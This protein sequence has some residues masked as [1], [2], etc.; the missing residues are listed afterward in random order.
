MCEQTLDTF[1]CVHTSDMNDLFEIA[2][3]S[4]ALNFKPRGKLTLVSNDV[5]AL[6]EFI[7]RVDVDVPAILSRDDDWLTKQELTL[8]GWYRQQIIKLRSYLFCETDNF[9]SLGADTI[10]LQPIDAN[11]LLQDGG[12]IL[13]YT[14]RTPFNRHYRYERR[15]VN[16]VARLLGVEPTVSRR[17]V[18]FINDLFCFNRGKLI[19][20]NRYLESL[21][22][23]NY[24]YTMLQTLN[25]K[26]NRFGEWTLYNVYLLDCLRDQGAI[27]N[28]AEGFLH[29]V[30]SPLGLRWHQ[31]DSKTVHLVHKRVNIDYVK[32]QIAGHNLAL[33]QYL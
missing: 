30:R 5:T 24:Y 20:L 2:L 3:R 18:D 26:T 25:G 33:A 9:C 10:L 6:Q 13:Y 23:P 8:P 1:I 16:A 17:Y 22:G 19:E 21:Y 29:Q 7:D 28:A 31:F 12:P 11:D 27:K 15:R 32:D 14:Q 4:Y